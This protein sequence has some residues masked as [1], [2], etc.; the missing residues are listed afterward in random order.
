MS[1]RSPDEPEPVGA[2]NLPRRDGSGHEVFGRESAVRENTGRDNVAKDNQNRE[3]AGRESTR[4]RPRGGDEPAWMWTDDDFTA[5]PEFSPDYDANLAPV[6]PTR[7]ALGAA[8]WRRTWLWVAAA[9]LGLALGGAAFVVKPPPYKATTSVLLTQSPSLSAQD[10]ILTEVA[11]VESRTVAEAAMRDLGLPL[12]VKAVEAFSAKISATSLTDRVIQITVK[13]KSPSQAVS[14]ARATATAFLRI[15]NDELRSA[16]RLTMAS[17]TEQISRGK[18]RLQALTAQIAALR[19]SGQAISQPSKLAGLDGQQN[20]LRN[21]LTGLVQAAT[22][23]ESTAAVTTATVVHGSQ[24]LDPASPSPRSR[25]R[26]PLLYFGGGLLGGLAVGFGLIITAALVSKRLRRRDDIARVLGGPVLLSVGRVRAGGLLGRSW[27]AVARRPAVRQIVAYLGK[28][29]PVGRETSTLAVVAVDDL[30]VPALTL[31]S[32]ASSYA[33]DG[34]RVLIA[35]LTPSMAVGR[36]L[37]VTEVGVKLTEADGHEVLVAVPE[38]GTG[39]P[40]GPVNTSSPVDEP[41]ERAY[42]TADIMLTLV[43][44]DPAVGA[45]HLPTWAGDAV[46]MLTAGM[47]SATKIHAVGEMIRAAGTAL[48]S[49]VLLG[50]DR[51]DESL[52]FATSLTDDLNAQLVT[53]RAHPD[54]VPIVGQ[55]GGAGDEKAAPEKVGDLEPIN[56]RDVNSGGM[57]GSEPSRTWRR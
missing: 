29:L 25:L 52:G 28:S 31:V 48:I 41:L 10:Q 17:L 33:A 35:D 21:A 56:G 14:A 37:D 50:A 3:K 34:K 47:S 43:T 4:G 44:L 26:Y 23:F 42:R 39:L 30:R 18:Q 57:I 6:T 46:V 27:P 9:L 40:Q 12:S 16:E 7:P 13:G 5:S 20:E 19:A 2:A 38:A 49:A 53:D 15:R 1:R 11:L 54:R 22:I 51:S 45:D 55:V 32:L 36:L 8:I 24:V